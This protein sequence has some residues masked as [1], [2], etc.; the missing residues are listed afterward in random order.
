M[1]EQ[2]DITID[3]LIVMVEQIDLSLANIK[4]IKSNV[5]KLVGTYLQIKKI[6]EKFNQ[7]NFEERFD[8]KYKNQE[9]II[10]I[11]KSSFIFSNI[12]IKNKINNSNSLYLFK[13]KNINF[14]WFCYLNAN[15]SEQPDHVHQIKSTQDYKMALNMFKIAVCLNKFRYGKKDTIKRIIIWIPVESKRDF[16]NDKITRITL[17]ESADNFEAFVASGVTWNNSLGRITIITRYEEV[18]KL[19]IHEL[20]HNYYIDGSECHDHLLHTINQYR[21]T[22][23]PTNI[24]KS[25]YDYE[26]SIYES[27]TELL[28]TY[29]YLIFS[30]LELNTPKDT[31]KKKLFAQVMV[32]ILYSYN[33]IG[34]LIKLNEYSNYSNFIS[35]QIF[36]GEIC[37]YEYYY[38]KGLMYNNFYLEHDFGLC[39]EPR[40]FEQ[41]Y[42]N[43]I[44]MI[45]KQKDNNDKLLESVYNNLKSQKNFK[46]QI[47]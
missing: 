6:W 27:Y 23:N 21:L 26:L 40:E 2:K 11:I 12:V 13:Y 22:K 3:N 16:P 47:H 19:L 20:I 41:I 1:T 35:K 31:I 30:N 33:T 44:N 28:S 5:N 14:Y 37:I 18:E 36:S 45:E 42:R 43:I 10:S 17:K 15:D 38:I 24:D 4:L 34:N 8:I 25:N 7:L 46:Y 32:E 29:F 39:S 9:Q